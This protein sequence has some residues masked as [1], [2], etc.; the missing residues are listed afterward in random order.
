MELLV[1]AEVFETV[2][3]D[4]VLRGEMLERWLGRDDDGDG[5]ILVGGGINTD[6]GDDSG[7]AVDGFEL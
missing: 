1:L 6:V 5:L 2:A 7:G 3:L 4:A